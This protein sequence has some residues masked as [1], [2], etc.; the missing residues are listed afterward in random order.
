[1]SDELYCDKCEAPLEPQPPG[2]PDHTPPVCVSC[3]L[4]W[5]VCVRCSEPMYEAM[6]PIVGFGKDGVVTMFQLPSLPA[7][8]FYDVASEAS[9]VYVSC[10]QTCGQLERSA[11]DER[12]TV[13][14]EDFANTEDYST[15]MAESARLRKQ[16]EPPP[17]PKSFLLKSKDGEYL[18]VTL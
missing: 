14:A 6:V 3:K 8:S 5:D 17:P 10:C 11:R 2:L 15:L 7:D 4:F 18:Q 16:S 9:T 12:Y 1:M 13:L